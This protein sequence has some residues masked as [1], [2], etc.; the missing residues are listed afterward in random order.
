MKKYQRIRTQIVKP[1]LECSLC[2]KKRINK[3]N[4]LL[5]MTDYMILHYDIID[6]KIIP[7]D[8]LTICPNC[9]SK[10]INDIHKWLSEKL[11]DKYKRELRVK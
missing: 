3:Q 5:W 4:D 11:Y 8:Y 1:I 10:P 9:R 6:D 7:F 2:R